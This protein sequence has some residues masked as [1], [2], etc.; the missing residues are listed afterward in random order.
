MKFKTGAAFFFCG[1]QRGVRVAQKID[2]SGSVLWVSTDAY[3]G[4]NLQSVLTW[5]MRGLQYRLH[6]LCSFERLVCQATDPV[7]A[8]LAL[9]RPPAQTG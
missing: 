9:L 6:L 7:T 5:D 1:V 8:G 4:G 3:A 2:H